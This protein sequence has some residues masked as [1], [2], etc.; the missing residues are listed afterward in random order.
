MAVALT[1]TFLTIPMANRRK[2][3]QTTALT[4]AGLALSAFNIIPSQ[5][6]RKKGR[7]VGHGDYRYRVDKTWGQQDPT[8]IPVKNCHEMV[9]DRQGRLFLLTD[10]PK[11]NIL[12]Y[13]KDGK[14][15]DT[16]TLDWPGAHGLTWFD[17]NGEERLFIT[18]TEINKVY[19]TTLDGKVLMELS[20][21]RESGVYTEAS[22]WKPTEVAVRPDGGFYVADGY[23]KNFITQYTAQGEYIRHFGGKG[24]GEAQFDCC[25]G[26]L[27]DTRP[28]H[29]G[30][31]LVTS[32]THNA[33]KRFTPEGQYLDT[34]ELP[35]CWICRPV[36]RQGKLYFAVI[37]TKDW[38]SYDGMVAVLDGNNRVVSLP[39]GSAPSYV[40][41]QLQ[42]PTYDDL[43]F[44]NPHD[45]CVDEDEN[46]YV[47]QWYSGRTYPVRLERL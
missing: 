3:L 36:I 1:L 21:P 5:S 10:H 22:Q 29:E 39:G 45:V 33:F 25:H 24:D 17:E 19:K 31:L 18:D 20:F 38:W 41:D 32:R 14:V 27:L 15:T 23:G 34:I 42:P 43:T 12:I 30:K 35:G 13:N 2:F 44:L 37:V 26:V 40:D 11:N 6:S 46:L 7:I 9:Q 4:G 47:A 8:R 16:W 28:G